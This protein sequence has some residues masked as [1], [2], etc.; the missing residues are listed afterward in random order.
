VKGAISG[1]RRDT[2]FDI[3]AVA[4]AA[5]LGFAATRGSPPVL[6]PLGGA[7]VAC[8]TALAFCLLLRRRRPLTVAWIVTAAA[9]AIAIVDLVAPGTLVPADL[10]RTAMPWLPPA[11][12]F[13]AYAVTAYAGARR[14]RRVPIAWAP[15]VALV[16]LGSHTWDAPPNSPWLLQS[17]IFIL[18]PALLGMYM[19]ARRRLMRSL[20][21]R[22]DRAER[23]QRLLAEQARIDERARLAAEMHD[24]VTHRVSLMVLRAGA[25]LMTADSEA[26]RQAAEELRAA[27]SQALDEL[28]DLVGI[29]RDSAA[30]ADNRRPTAATALSAPDQHVPIPD[31][32][33]LLA[34]SQSVG[35]PVAYVE[36]GEPM[37][38]S[39]V[40][41]RT[42]Y[43][44][45]QE[46]LTNVRKHAPGASTQ[47]HV[48]YCAGRV[49]LTIHNAI[50][51]ASA[52][53]ALTAGRSGTGLLGLRQRVELIE[54]TLEAGP[55]PDGGF[56]LVATLPA[57]APTTQRLED[58]TL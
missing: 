28:R 48:Q 14:L 31:L 22:A 56:D 35:V 38:V 55:S 2:A 41:G 27:G 51:T 40:V 24:V 21:E 50:S 25:L 43:R 12:P 19:A 34:E 7:T 5:V 13:A 44:V 37:L 3:A 10:E 26:T 29:L 30:G 8:Q 4:I 42:A 54:G 16:I 23:E 18:V 58:V 17:L 20:V 39:P 11:A 49:S 57:L 32:S 53:P 9:A 1:P 45:V 6:E 46:A 33:A 52:D 36:E 15:V 47:V